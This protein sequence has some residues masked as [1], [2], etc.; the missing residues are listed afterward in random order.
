MSTS[1]DRPDIVIVSERD[2]HILELTVP[3]NTFKNLEEARYRKQA[4]YQP[5]I[6]DLEAHPNINKVLYSTVEVGSLG[7]YT[8]SAIQ[9]LR[10]A[11]PSITKNQAKELLDKAAKVAVGCSYHVFRARQCTDWDSNKSL[12]M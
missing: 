12:Y 4:K 8:F 10:E 2:V 9:A 7:H 5:L 6:T 3:A 11:Y 1:S